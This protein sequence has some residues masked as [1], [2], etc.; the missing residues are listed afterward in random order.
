MTLNKLTHFYP[1][2]VDALV[3][4]PAGTNA[5][6][7]ANAGGGFSVTNLVLT[8][9]DATNF[10]SLP[11]NSRLATGTNKPTAFFPVIQFP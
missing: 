2:D 6:I 3:V 10:P 7:M 9:D 4:S 1:A 11:F 8:F 5:L